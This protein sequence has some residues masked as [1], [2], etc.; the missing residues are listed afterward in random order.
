VAFYD[1]ATLEQTGKVEIP[2]GQPVPLAGFPGSASYSEAAGLLFVGS[3]TAAVV[4]VV[5]VA[6]RALKDPLVVPTAGAGNDIIVVVAVEGYVLA[7]SF[8]DGIAYKLD[9][10]QQVPGTVT[11][12]VAET[13]PGEGPVDALL[14]DGKVYVVL[15]LSSKVAALDLATGKAEYPW[16]TGAAANRVA[17]QDGMLF[18]VNSMDNNL[19]RIDLA[20][21]D[22]TPGFASFD[23]GTNPWEIGT[24]NKLGFVTGYLSNALYKVDLETGDVLATAQ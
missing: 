24:S 1:P 8:N 11:Y 12:E 6:A 23:P 13:G 22:A 16:T 7:I 18:I 14:L 5:D 3:G 4:F 2:A 21:K 17:A 9:P 15:T 19:T 20:T 10:A